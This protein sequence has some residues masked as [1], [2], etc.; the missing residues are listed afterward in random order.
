MIF[1]LPYIGVDEYDE[2]NR[3][4]VT[5]INQL[6]RL[7]LVARGGCP[8]EKINEIV[9]KMEKELLKERMG[10]L[11]LFRGYCMEFFFHCLREVLEP[12]TESPKEMSS[13]NLAIEIKKYIQ[14]NYSRKIT[15]ED[16]SDALHISPRHAQRI[17]SDYFGVSYAKT[18]N[19][20][21][22]NYAKNYLARTNLTIDEIAERVG[23]S[24]A[25]AM[26]R[27][28]REHERMSVNEYRVMQK[29]RMLTKQDSFDITGL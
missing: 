21:R 13:L 2:A 10:W 7:E 20:Y 3:P 16:I 6:S 28:F 14:S 1:D 12:V 24:S 27:L 22:M 23:L 11:F 18:L 26:S 4:L 9:N 8:V 5:K 25:Q 29:K 17:F 15:L 19:L